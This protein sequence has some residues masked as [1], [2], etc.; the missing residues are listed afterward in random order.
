MVWVVVHTKIPVI[1]VFED[2][3][4]AMDLVKWLHKM[5][6]Q[7]DKNVTYTIY[8]ERGIK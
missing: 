5:E 8:V 6:E 3:E 1:E 4:K 2:K 7:K